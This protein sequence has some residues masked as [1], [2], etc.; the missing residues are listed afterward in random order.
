MH[1]CLLLDELS[2]SW[3]LWLLGVRACTSTN[4]RQ[5]LTQSLT[6]QQTVC[7]RCVPSFS[8]ILFQGSGLLLDE[9]ITM[10]FTLQC[11]NPG[12]PHAFEAFG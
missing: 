12:P 8:A 11:G 6:S 9:N 2:I 7:P 3:L 4:T 10:S 1:Q 5:R